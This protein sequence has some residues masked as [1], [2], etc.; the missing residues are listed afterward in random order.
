[1][2]VLSKEKLLVC[3]QIIDESST[4]FSFF[5]RWIEEL[6]TRYDKVTVLCLYEGKHNLNTRFENVKV[7]S[8]GKE[9]GQS[10]LKY[11]WKFYKY[12]WKMRHEYR[13]VFVH[14]NRE[15]VLLGGV[16]WKLLGKKVFLWS[17]H[18]MGNFLTNIAGYFCNKVFYTSK[19]SYTANFK[20]AFQM[21]VGVDVKNF[22]ENKHFENYKYNSKMSNSVLFLSRLSPS[23][24]P[25]IVLKALKNLEVKNSG[26]SFVATFVGG[27]DKDKFPNYEQEIYELNGDL[28]FKN[29]I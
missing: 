25:D 22:L 11:I 13:S 15:Y 6:A 9:G 10:R 4:V 7:C 20:N 21:P 1:M 23:K 17:N 28:N 5:V 26:L 27:P 12:I 3:C 18:Y 29:K 8:L 2:D 16:V 19:F 14:Q 24:H